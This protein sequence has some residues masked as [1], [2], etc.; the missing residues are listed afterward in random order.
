MDG[1]PLDD[2]GINSVLGDFNNDSQEDLLLYFQAENCT[3]YNGGTETFA[4]IIY[5]DG[6]AKSDLMSE[7]RNAIQSEYQQSENENEK[8]REV[9]DAYLA[10]TTTINGYRI[11]V[12]GD[13]RLYTETDA[14]CCP[15]YSGT[16]VYELKG[17]KMQ[18]KVS[19]NENS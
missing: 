13:F 16:Y 15:S 14:H 18:I 7:K 17:K 1:L 19:E 3:G 9:T 4:K 5:S 11:G 2:G 12:T 8:L 6:T 10:T